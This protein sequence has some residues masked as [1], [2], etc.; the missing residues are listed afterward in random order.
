LISGA[1]IVLYS[2]DAEA[3]REF[4]RKILKFPHVDAGEGWL[5]F[6]LPPAEVAIH[7]AEE[8]GSHELYLMC[9]DL[10]AT[11]KALKEK[12]VK[13][14]PPVDEGRGVL[15]RVKLPGGG[16][17]GLYQPKHPLAHR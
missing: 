7:P 9:D 8:N 12:K 5:I 4:F 2:K 14:S 15:A 11:I 10:K 17:L 16:D 13:C 1:H 3:D 6:A